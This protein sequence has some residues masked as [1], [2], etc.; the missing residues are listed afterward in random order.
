MDCVVYKGRPDG[1]NSQRAGSASDEKGQVTQA[2]RKGTR[3]SRLLAK[4]PQQTMMHWAMT[5]HIITK[6]NFHTRLQYYFGRSRHSTTGISRLKRPRT[7]QSLPPRFLLLTSR[8]H[9]LGVSSSRFQGSP[10]LSSAAHGPQW[11]VSTHKNTA[12]IHY[13]ANMEYS[14]QVPIISTFQFPPHP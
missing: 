4:S 6:F 9:L 13:H 5:N 10:T 8:R 11:N 2:I 12:S 3:N 7:T 14:V 1:R